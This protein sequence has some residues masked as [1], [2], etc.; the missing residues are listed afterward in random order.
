[1]LFSA[2]NKLRSLVTRL[3]RSANG[4]ERPFTQKLP[5]LPLALVIPSGALGTL[6]AI[7]MVQMLRRSLHGPGFRA[8]WIGDAIKTWRANAAEYTVAVG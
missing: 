7:A 4:T 5:K 2:A 8:E 6:A 3:W 1:M